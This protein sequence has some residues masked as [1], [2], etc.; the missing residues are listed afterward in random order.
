[1]TTYIY[2][3][4]STDRQDYEAQTLELQKR[5]PDAI[6]YSEKV[7]GVK[8]KRELEKLLSVIQPGD[9][10]VIYALDRIGRR[11]KDI[12]IILENLLDKKITIKTHRE[13]F[14]YD[15]FMSRAFLQLM[16]IFSELER[17][18]ASERTRARYQVVKRN[19]GRW[20]RKKSIPDEVIHGACDAVISR[21]LSIRSAAK[22]F[23]ISYKHL[24]NKLVERKNLSLG[25]N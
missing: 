10:L 16:G 15:D 13:T 24:H 5:Y 23:K 14:N 21:G 2:S 22:E 19:G 17:N 18:L 7:S 11:L 3:R 12:L 8:R 25:Q 6:V 1:M 4:V 9:T 20:G